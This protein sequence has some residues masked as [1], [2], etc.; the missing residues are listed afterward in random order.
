LL[1]GIFLVS[2]F[3]SV[4]EPVEVSGTFK[5][6]LSSSV[7][8]LSLQSMSG[9]WFETA[10]SRQ[11]KKI[12]QKNCQCLTSTFTIH[13]NKLHVVNECLNK[14]TD[15]IVAVNGTLTQVIPDSFP[16]AFH[17][18]FK[19]E[20][21][22]GASVVEAQKED[23]V[24]KRKL[25]TLKLKVKENDLDVKKE[26]EDIKKG[27]MEVGK[28]DDEQ[29]KEKVG[30]EK[31][32]NKEDLAKIIKEKDINFLVLK[33]VEDKTLLICGPTNELIWVLSRNT[34]L[35]ESIFNS[36]NDEAKRLGFQSLVKSHSC[37]ADSVIHLT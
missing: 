27:D 32:I 35:D 18:E 15:K 28:I 17:M 7:R 16:G 1:F 29:K 26:G 13:K 23:I 24:K 37:P 34:T 11:V 31:N 21:K 4:S 2:A 10:S 12:F 3:E 25:G 33:N 6:P 9:K 19:S 36:F 5:L 22:S 14:T 20:N 30:E 8:S